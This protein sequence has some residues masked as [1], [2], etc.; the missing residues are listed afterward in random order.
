MKK[1]VLFIA[2]ITLVSCTVEEKP[3]IYGTDDCALC[4]MLIMDQRYGTEIV[5]TKGRVY[6]FDAIECLV[7]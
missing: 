2:I 7:E 6:K 3:I 4:K 5:T 1:P